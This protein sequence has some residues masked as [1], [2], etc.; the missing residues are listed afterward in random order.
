MHEICDKAPSDSTLLPKLNSDSLN[1][2][3]EAGS[4]FFVGKYEEYWNRLVSSLSGAEAKKAAW[5]RI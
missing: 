4:E 2:G 5:A 1:S 3:F